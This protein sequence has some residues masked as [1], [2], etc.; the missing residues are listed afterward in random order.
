MNMQCDYSKIIVRQ[1]KEQGY[2][3][4]G[5]I[6]GVRFPVYRRGPDQVVVAPPFTVPS[7]GLDRML[8]FQ[9]AVQQSFEKMLKRLIESLRDLM[10]EGPGSITLMLMGGGTLELPEWFLA[11]LREMGIEV[12]FILPEEMEI[13]VPYHDD[14]RNSWMAARH[15]RG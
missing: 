4:G 9:D 15:E 6:R 14:D 13:E 12:R 3:D 7:R 10:G 5:S 2:R 11:A 1:L 8:P